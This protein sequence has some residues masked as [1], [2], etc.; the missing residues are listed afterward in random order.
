MEQEPLEAARERVVLELSSLFAR[1]S[2]P[3]EELDRRLELAYAARSIADLDGL[4]PGVGSL[5]AAPSPGGYPPAPVQ[6]RPA[7]TPADLDLSP[8][9]ARRG[10]RRVLAVM[11]DTK[12]RGT[13]LVPPRLEIVAVMASLTVDMRDATFA[14]METE[15]DMKVLMAQVTIIVP[16]GMRVIDDASAV[17]AEH[18]CEEHVQGGAANAP[19]LRINGWSAMAELVVRD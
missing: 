14:S 3:M 2:I 5:P 4:V 12:R 8:G 13:W 6:W 7:A 15:I 19:V 18:K 17:L 10:Q 11:S 9:A 16:R 1:D